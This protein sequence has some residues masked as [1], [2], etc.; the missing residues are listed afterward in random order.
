MTSTIGRG[1]VAGAFGTMLLNAATYL[2]MALTG[3]PASSTPGESVRR[4]AARLGVRPPDDEHR[5]QAYGALGGIAV[6]VGLGI[7][8]SVARSSGVRLPGPLGATAIAGFAMTATN[9]PMA[10]M[11]VSDPRD[12]SIADW[13]RDVAPHLAYGA[14]VRWAMDRM[15]RQDRVRPGTGRV[16]GRR[17]A[18]TRPAPGMPASEGP[19]R[20]REAR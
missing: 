7:V 13:T 8:A 11:G 10:A 2:D 20:Y 14:G 18:G 3:R 9:A 19:G 12:W 1:V 17:S 6:G 5:L 4:S 16:L 15:D